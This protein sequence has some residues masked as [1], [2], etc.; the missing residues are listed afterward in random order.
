M[1]ASPL[2]SLKKLDHWILSVNRSLMITLLGVMAAIIFVSVSIRYL[3]DYSIPWAEELSRYLMVWLMFLGI[4]PVMRLGGHIAI[5]TFPKI[6]S[7]TS[8]VILRAI[9]ALIIGVFFMTLLWVG[10]LYMQKTIPQSTAVLEISFAWVSASVPIGF[11]LAL[12]HG[13]A[14]AAPYVKSGAYETSDDLNIDE[15]GAV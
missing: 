3:S 13:V 15:A 10:W 4:G 14:V 1:N 12:W 8:A 9:I 2:S 7:G 5:D 6:L 11:A